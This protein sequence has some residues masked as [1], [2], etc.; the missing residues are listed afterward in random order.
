MNEDQLYDHFRFL[1]VLA[2]NFVDNKILV[3]FQFHLLV[4]Y[5]FIVCVILLLLLFK[6]A[7]LR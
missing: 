7:D 1:F 3:D 4:S 6:S 2:V 5:L